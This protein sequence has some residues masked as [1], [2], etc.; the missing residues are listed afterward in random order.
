L[1]D[2]RNKISPNEILFI[3]DA[4]SGQD[5]YNVANE[6]NKN[7]DLTGFIITKLD[8][9]ANAGAALS[10]V[11]LLNIGIKFSG[12]GERIGS[13]ELFYPERIANRILGLGD[14]LTLAEKA[15]EVSDEQRTKKSFARMVSGKMDF[16]D[17]LIQMQQM[18][19]MGSMSSIM[20]MLPNMPKIDE[21]R[22]DEAEE[23]MRI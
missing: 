2:I 19:K 23:K 11:S 14:I 18:T 15:S 1:I 10:L 7:L 12:T 8:T 21:S 6:F 20:K 13:F 16:E 22:I 17:L 4:L 3:A 9:D 5:I